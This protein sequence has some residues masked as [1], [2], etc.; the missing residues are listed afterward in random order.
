MIC[1]RAKGIT[2]DFPGVRALDGVDFDLEKGEIHALVGENGAGKS[3]LVKI[4]A[5]V[6]KPTQGDLSLEERSVAFASPREAAKHIG[7]VHQER[8]LVPFFSGT[9]NLF[10]GQELRSAGFLQKSEMG[11]RAREFIAQYK[12]DIDPDRPVRE[13]GVG[14][15]EMLVILKIL[16]GTLPFSFS[17]SRRRLSAS[18][19]ARSFLASFAS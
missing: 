8:E 19:R 1:L 7:V 4:L 11:E 3:T 14:D 5:G 10:L 9:A 2:K 17:T 6:Y 12:L 15:Q 16:F 13:L 18:R